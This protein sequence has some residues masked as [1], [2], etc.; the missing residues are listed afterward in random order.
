MAITIIVFILILGL[1]IFVHELG[2]FV[3]AKRAGIKVEEFGFGFPPRIWGIKRGETIYSINWI[4]LGGFVKIYGEDGQDKNNKRSFGSK[5]VSKRAWILASGVLMNFL[6][7]AVLLA[8]GF[9]IGSPELIDENQTNVKNPQVMI[10]QT[11]LDSPAQEAG[12]MMGDIIIELAYNHDQV[13]VI[14]TQQVLD[15]T[16][17][18]KGNEILVTIKRGEEIFDKKI[19]ARD[20]HSKDEG[21][22][23]IVVARIAIVSYPIHISIYKGFVSTIETTIAIIVA[24]GGILY[25]LFTSG[26]LARDIAGPVGI[27]VLTGQAAKLG[28]VYILHQP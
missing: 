4:P 25:N 9:G 18:Y 27:F 2:H 26:Q 7:A 10:T 8:I 13:K 3:T 12:L 23:G 17:K 19:L 15:F 6:L 16:D 1:L 14:K 5:P 20:V 21:P 22:L 24:F 28:L 11:A